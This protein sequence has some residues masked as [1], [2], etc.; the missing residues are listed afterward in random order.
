MRLGLVTIALLSGVGLAM[1]VGMNNGLRARMGHPFLA[2]FTSFLVGSV[3]LA[4]YLAITRPSLPDRSD[5]ARAPMWIWMGGLVGAAYI[6]S[7]AAFASKL[8]AAP[9]LSLIITGQIVASL[10][11]DHYGLIGFPQR[12]INPN[13]L[14]GAALILA[15]VILVVW[16]PNEAAREVLVEESPI[17]T[18]QE[19]ARP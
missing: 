4:I 7:A 13:R 14:I 1:Q 17:T 5:F 10:V 6:A 2:A 16:K 19:P 9:W 3:A 15:G 12:A 8:G 18:T 11:M